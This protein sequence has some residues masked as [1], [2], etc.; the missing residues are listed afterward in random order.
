[1]ECAMHI[2]TANVE[3][4]NQ[5]NKLFNATKKNKRQKERERDYFQIKLHAMQTLNAI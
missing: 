1:M 3:E 5:F 2:K 4:S